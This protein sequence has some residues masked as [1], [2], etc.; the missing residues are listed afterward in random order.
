MSGVLNTNCLY[1]TNCRQSQL[2]HSQ[3][4]KGKNKQ[5][6]TLCPM[7]L[8][9]LRLLAVVRLSSNYHNFRNSKLA[10][11]FLINFFLH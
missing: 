6:T 2:I 4:K 3:R 1:R 8:Y 9:A 5:Q 7:C 10:N 11:T